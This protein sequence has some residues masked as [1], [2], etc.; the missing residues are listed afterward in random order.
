MGDKI[1]KNLGKII[2]YS[3]CAALM[4]SI[5]C[6]RLFVGTVIT[7][8][9]ESMV[10][11]FNDGDFILTT[12]LHDNDTLNVG[13]IV[14]LKEDGKYLVKRIYG[15]P[16]TTTDIDIV[17]NIPAVEL[18]DDEYY[19]VGDNY[20]VSRDSRSFGPVKRDS[21][22]FKYAGVRWNQV[23]FLISTALP[24]ILLVAAITI[25]TIPADKKKVSAQT[26]A[27]TE[28]ECIDEEC[29]TDNSAQLETTEC[30]LVDCEKLT[31]TN[32]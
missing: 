2:G 21:I 18:G 4:V 24:V 14:I 1:K 27:N 10:P 29:D 28:S 9:G 8:S 32:N 6:L 12:I 16:N 5:I 25:V 31:T 7:V 30:E 17:K 22:T 3:V 11:T 15:T 26:T 23:T 20:E 19:V 13:D